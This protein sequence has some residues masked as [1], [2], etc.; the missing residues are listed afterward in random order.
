MK[1]YTQVFGEVTLY[2]ETSKM[3]SATQV[4]T[5]AVIDYKTEADEEY[6]YQIA[7]GKYS[8]YTAEQIARIEALLAAKA[9]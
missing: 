8:R 5:S 9:N 4:L 3:Q 7:E 6:K 1:F 2:A